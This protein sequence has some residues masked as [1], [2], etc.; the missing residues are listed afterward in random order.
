MLDTRGYIH[1]RRGDLTAA[2]ADLNLAVDR[3]E[4][5]YQGEERTRHRREFN[6][7]LDRLRKSLAVIRYHR[8]LVFDA[9]GQSKK[10]EADRRRV[11]E[12]GFAPA[13]SL[14]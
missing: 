9:L 2:E 8:A 10:A 14:F 7:P 13:P 6:Q 1:F 12:L 3:T 11:R 4:Q 5:D